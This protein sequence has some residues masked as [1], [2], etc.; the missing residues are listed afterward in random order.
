MI[1]IL[2]NLPEDE[3][4]CWRTAWAWASKVPVS[5]PTTYSVLITEQLINLRMQGFV[6]EWAMSGHPASQRAWAR[7][8]AARL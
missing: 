1:M 8:I 7:R 5:L 6:Y 4:R 2:K 3:D